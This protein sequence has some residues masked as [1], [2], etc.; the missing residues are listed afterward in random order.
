VRIGYHCSHE[1]YPPS[2]LLELVARAEQAGFRSAMCSDHF[3]PW[4][5][6]QGESGFAWSWL[7]AALQCTTLPF[8]VVTV[9]GGWRY[10]PAIVAQAAATLDEMF[11]GRFWI[12]PGSGEALNEHIVGGH[13]PDK[14]ERNARLL[15]G[16]EI[17][18]AL[19]RGETVTHKGLIRVEEARLYTVPTRPPL[20]VGAALSP[21]TARW[22]GGWADGL[23]TIWAEHDALREM[24]EA[25]GEGGGEGK[26]IF[27]QAQLAFGRDRE[28]AL[29]EAWEQWRSAQF[30]SAVLA[31]LRMPAEFD[32]AARTMRP[33]DVDQR[34][35]V[36][37]DW[38][39]HLDWLAEVAAL[40]FEE[41]NI[42]NVPRSEQERFIDVFGERVLPELMRGAAT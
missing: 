21:G 34:L 32:D 37:D 7:G 42:H 24:I 29:R 28:R 31:T 8:G 19:W 17:I 3:H 30:D 41:I 16:V 10:H 11:P 2:R 14:S 6:A 12:A 9:P 22:M 1:Q 23:I 40:G 20:I 5:E 35:R 26:P 4:S 39:Q 27:L 36:S 18:R 15:E 25:F 33:E 38:R 13:W